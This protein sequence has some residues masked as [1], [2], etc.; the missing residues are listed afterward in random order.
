MNIRRRLIP[1]LPLGAALL[2]AAAC[3]RADGT[4]AMAVPH[5]SVFAAIIALT[6]YVT[7]VA[8]KRVKTT[9]DFYAGGGCQ[10]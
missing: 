1:A 8:A 3:V 7:Y 10:V 5:F 9:A 2:L 4:D 6:M